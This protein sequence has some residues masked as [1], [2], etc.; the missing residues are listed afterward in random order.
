MSQNI[1]DRKTQL[2]H[3]ATCRTKG[4]YLKTKKYKISTMNSH[5]YISLSL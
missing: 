1:S 3:I 2:P 4:I 5:K